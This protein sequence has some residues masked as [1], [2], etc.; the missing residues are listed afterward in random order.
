MQP[1]SV[2]P[3][4]TPR[5][6]AINGIAI[7]WLLSGFLWI[8]AKY[9]GLTLQ[10]TQI[11]IEKVPSRFTG[12][13]SRHHL[14]QRRHRSSALVPDAKIAGRGER[15][16]V[17]SRV[18][19]YGSEL[20]QSWQCDEKKPACGPCTRLGRCCDG[21][22]TKLEFRDVSSSLA[23]TRGHRVQRSKGPV[24][25]QQE[26]TAQSTRDIMWHASYR[27]SPCSSQTT[28]SDSA[29]SLAPSQIPCSADFKIDLTLK[30]D[31][32][33]FYMSIWE[34]QCAPAIHPVFRKLIRLGNLSP[35]IVNTTMAI[36]ARQLSRMLP[37]PRESNSL[38][39]PGSSFRPDLRQQHISGG[40]SS[41]AMRSVAQWTQTDFNRDPTTAL[42]V[43]TM[44]CYLESLMSNFQG[45]Y[46]HSAAVGT[47]IKTEGLRKA[48]PDSYMA[49]LA[50]AWVQSK[51][52]NW[53]RRL[54]F[55]TPTF[56]KDHPALVTQSTI[57]SLSAI[58]NSSRVVI[59][60]LLCESYR[61]STAIF[62]Y[63]CGDVV[64]MELAMLSTP[65]H[66]LKPPPSSYL[67]A[68]L[69]TQEERLNYQR[70]SLNQWHD[71][72]SPSDLPIDSYST[73]PSDN[74]WD[75]GNLQVDPLR[76]NSHDAAMNFAYYITARVM[77]CTEYLTAFQSEHFHA[78]IGDAYK[79]V[80]PW[81]ILLLR[82]TAS[83]N[84]ENCMKLNTYTVGIS[85]LLL[86]C[87][88]RS[89]NF[90]IGLWVED[91]LDQRYKEGCLE[92][93]SFPIF[94]ILQV[95]RII[96]Q[97]RKSGRHVYAVC[98][99]TDDGGGVG[100]FDSYNS[101]RL[102]SVLVYGWC[103]GSQCF[104]VRHIVLDT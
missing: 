51:L 53:W 90:S 30:P 89:G 97:E 11:S 55:S 21:Y 100:K 46:L 47:L 79:I 99:P 72:L 87:V 52:H 40:F 101:Q 39:L 67:S 28:G 93:G 27:N 12:C 6:L 24:S 23:E 36:A 19:Y 75:S 81:V 82:L 13:I 35:V 37:R 83:I 66:K 7:L 76:F 14:A 18:G 2:S 9:S 102:A 69:S 5:P 50:S 95:L 33:T 16:S 92:E 48:Q 88:L 74:R 56:Q 22:V 78:K 71:R 32:E 20:T 49:E 60:T 4:P 25:P 62:M 77:Q 41:S 1:S 42:A 104:Y 10:S 63:H 98:Q 86:A 8:S 45:F 64:D 54:H 43:L 91:W 44:F 80:E 73:S 96:N 68:F 31:M 84:W 61:L 34:I 57:L 3:F 85:G 58:V 17:R 103:L 59:L 15:R 29:H 38:D 26:A 70:F 65:F 94:Q